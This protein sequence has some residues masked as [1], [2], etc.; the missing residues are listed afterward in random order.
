MIRENV[1]YD[2][3]HLLLPYICLYNLGYAV[4]VSLGYAVGV[5]LSIRKRGRLHRSYI[6]GRYEKIYGRSISSVIYLFFCEGYQ[7]LVLY[8]LHGS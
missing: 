5:S 4:G 7:M 1:F 3:K 2:A 8:I 6:V